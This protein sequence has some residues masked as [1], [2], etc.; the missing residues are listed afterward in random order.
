MGCALSQLLSKTMEINPRSGQILCAAIVDC[1]YTCA[2]CH[3]QLAVKI[4][5]KM[6][7][8]EAASLPITA[9]TA[10][11]SLVSM[12]MLC[13]EDPILV[14]FG[15][16]GTGQMAIQIAQI[17]GSEVFV[18]VGTQDKRNLIIDIYHIPEDH[19]F[20]SRDTSFAKDIVR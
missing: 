11:H 3:E 10:H 13:Q 12:A 9:I 18:T 8:T 14:H 6:P 7:Y 16:G 15:A 5:G 4:P 17:I 20:D 1:M 19:I 2:R